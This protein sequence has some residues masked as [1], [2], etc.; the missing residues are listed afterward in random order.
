MIIW[1]SSVVNPKR[2]DGMAQDS[3]APSKDPILGIE[4]LLAW[5]FFIRKTSATSGSA[6]CGSDRYKD[7]PPVDA[8][9][10]Y[11]DWLSGGGDPCQQD[12]GSWTEAALQQKRFCRSPWAITRRHLSIQNLRCVPRS[13]EQTAGC[14]ANHQYV[15]FLT[16]PVLYL[17]AMNSQF[18]SSRFMVRKR[19]LL[20]P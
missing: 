11:S 2:R 1:V 6:V 13:R 12:Q 14:W 5:L 15:R 7:H 9:G 19:R 20:H 8:P 16:Y 17:W 10:D 18:F 4:R 3:L